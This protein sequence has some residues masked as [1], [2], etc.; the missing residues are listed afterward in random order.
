MMN[1]DNNNNNDMGE[2]TTKERMRRKD[3]SVRLI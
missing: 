3:L 1:S 2:G